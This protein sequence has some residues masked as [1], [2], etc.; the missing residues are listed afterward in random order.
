MLKSIPHS[1]LSRADLSKKL[2][3]QTG[4][5]KESQAHL[6]SGEKK[7]L[8][9]QE[10]I[11]VLTKAVEATSDGVFIIDAKH[12]DFPLTYANQSF[13]NMI[14]YSKAEVINKNY[15]LLYGKTADHR[16]VSEI[17]DAIK[18]SRPFHGEILNFARNGR[19]YW[20]LLRITP[21]RGRDGFVTHF[22]GIQ[23]DVTLMREKEIELE[24]QREE[25]MH[26]T[27]VGKL[28]EFVSSLAHE[29]SQ[30]LTSILSY[31]QAARR[32]LS[33]REPELQE[34]LSY[35]INDDHRAADVI[36]RLRSLLKKGKPEIGPI[37]VNTLIKD[38]VALIST[39]P[40]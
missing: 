26:V 24:E 35:I 21:V 34:I 5:L 6:R 3:Q 9:S 11:N 7:Q 33:G 22:L 4:E 17:K 2:R 29:I 15:F 14:G 25:I 39:T 30:P 16:V 13:Y 32:M 37:D 20:S 12:R 28:A 8:K 36:Q 19:K 18:R 27:R 31:A 1:G 38:T 23:A 10:Q 40:R